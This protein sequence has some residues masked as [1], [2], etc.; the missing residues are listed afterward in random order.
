MP[1]VSSSQIDG[2]KQTDAG[3]HKVAPTI[4][5]SVSAEHVARQLEELGPMPQVAMEVM[6]LTEDPESDS[7]DIERTVTRDPV[8]AAKVL[9]MANSAFFSKGQPCQTLQQASTRLGMKMVRNLVVSS[10]VAGMMRKPQ[11]SYAYEPFGLCKHSLVLALLSGEVIHALGLPRT[12]VDELFLDGLLHDAGKL[13]L[14]PLLGGHVSSTGRL[15]TQRERELAGTDHCAVGVM[16]AEHWKLPAHTSEV[17]AH[18]H[19]VAAAA[20]QYRQHAAIINVTDWLTNHF[21]TGLGENVQ[22]DQ[23]F[24]PAVLDTLGV[25][26][27]RLSALPE[28]LDDAMA[29]VL[30]FC[31]S[32]L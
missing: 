26:A 23:T 10:C 31:S 21:G 17:I 19:D 7:R 11:K 15:G 30:Q 12:L 3:P 16:M 24:D 6:Q 29:Q 4:A 9:T 14:D 13:V 20:P 8:I 1:I 18:H 27:D 22:L 32:V 2:L 25:D 5:R 28:E